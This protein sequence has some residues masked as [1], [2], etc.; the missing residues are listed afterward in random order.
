MI[1]KRWKKIKDKK[2]K[3]KKKKNLW[4]NTKKEK[5][6]KWKKIKRNKGEETSRERER[7]KIKRGFYLLSKIY[8]DRVIGFHRS[9]RQSRSTQRELRVGTKIR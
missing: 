7:D 5:K 9:K 4:D 8:G 6:K 2:K 3:K 1:I